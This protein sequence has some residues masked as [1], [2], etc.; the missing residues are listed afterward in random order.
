VWK[1][2]RPPLKIVTRDE[3]LA[4]IQ[5][6]PDR[7]SYRTGII[8]PPIE[9]CEADGRQIAVVS[10]PWKDTPIYRIEDRSSEGG[11]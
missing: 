7:R 6:F 9:V 4:Y 2:R 8:E 10:Y 11:S 5:Q 1:V 3:W